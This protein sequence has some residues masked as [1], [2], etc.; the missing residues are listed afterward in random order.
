MFFIDEPLA[1]FSPLLDFI[2]PD[3]EFKE[4]NRL[5]RNH[6]F[7]FPFP[8]GADVFGELGDD[9]AEALAESWSAKQR[10]SA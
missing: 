5:E 6:R 3:E 10:E 7:N 8:W 9:G 1:S 2:I 4:L